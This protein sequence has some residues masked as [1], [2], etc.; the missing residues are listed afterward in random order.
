MTNL[1]L[2]SF[3][4]G[5]HFSQA[6]PEIISVRGLPLADLL[7][8]SQCHNL[9]A[10]VDQIEQQIAGLTEAE[11]QIH[12]HLHPAGVTRRQHLLESLS[13]FYEICEA[14]NHA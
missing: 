3:H 4:H 14:E 5:H 1:T 12:Q 11:I 13:A 2:T 9:D 7:P 8:A 10:F 6:M